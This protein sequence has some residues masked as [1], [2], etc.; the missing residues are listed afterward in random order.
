MNN[1][2]NRQEVGYVLLEECEILLVMDAFSPCVDAALAEWYHVSLR[3]DSTSNRD[4][5]QGE[6][7]HLSNE[8]CDLILRPCISSD[9][10][11]ESSSHAWTNATHIIP[12]NG[13]VS[14]MS[15]E[16]PS[17]KICDS[18]HPPITKNDESPF[19]LK[20]RSDA[21]LL[22]G[23]A[24]EINE[25]QEKGSSQ[26][27]DDPHEKNGRSSGGSHLRQLRMEKAQV[28]L[29]ENY[30]QISENASRTDMSAQMHPASDRENSS[31]TYTRT[32]ASLLVTFSLPNHPQNIYS[33]II[34]LGDDRNHAR[35]NGAKSIC[36][37]KMLSTAH[38]LIGS[39]IRCDWDRLD[40]TKKL[41]Q[42]KALSRRNKQTSLGTGRPNSSLTPF[43]FP[44]SLNMESL[45]E[46]ICG[47]STHFS[48]DLHKKRETLGDANNHKSLK[49]CSSKRVEFLDLPSDIIAESVAT[50]LRSKSLHALRATNR[51]LYVLLREVVPGLKLKLFQHQIRS[52]EWMEMRERRCIT[53]GDVLRV[54]ERMTS[55][56]Y[57]LDEGAKV[58]GGDYHRAVTGG[59]TVLLIPRANSNCADAPGPR[60][61]DL[62]SGCEASFA[63]APRSITKCARGGLLCDDPGLGKTI[64]IISLILRS[65]GLTTQAKANSDQDGDDDNLFYSYWC[66]SFLTK[67]VRKCAL[68]E[69]INCLI[70][71]DCES[72]W[73]LPPIDQYLDGCPDY[74][75]VISTP[76][77]LEDIRNICNKSD[78]RDFKGFEA[79]VMLCFSNAM[80]Y[81]PPHHC[82]Y[83]AAKRL[84]NNFGTLLVEFKK[85]QL[86]VASKS[87]HRAVKDPDTRSLV[88]AFQ[89]RKRREYQATLVSSS[90]TLLVVPAPLLSHW[91]EQMILHI[92]FRYIIEHGSLSSSIYY[93]TSKRNINISHTS[94]SF[95]L[96]SIT[97]PVLFIDDGSKV[98][99]QPSILA[100]FPIVLTTC[101]RFTSEWKNGS[102]EREIRASKNMRSSSEIYW[103]DDEPQA[104]PLLKVSWLRVIVDEGHV[105]G[106]STNN[107]IQFAS[108]LTVERTWAMTGTPTQQIATQTGLR[109]LY[110][111][112]NFVKHDFFDRQLGREKCW[113]DLISSGWIAGSLASFFRLKQLVSYLM[114]RHTKADLVEIPP[115]IFSTTHI[116][117]SQPETTTYNTI[118]SSIK[119]NIITTSMKGKTSGWQDSLLNP[120]QSRHASLALTNL[121][122]ACCGGAQIVP[123]ILQ[124]HWDETLVI[125]RDIH[126]LH[127]VQVNLIN[128]FIYRAQAAELSGC[129]CCGLQLQTLFIIPCGHLVCTECIDSKSTT[130]PVCQQS[131]DVDSFQRLQPGFNFQFCLKLKNEEEERKNRFAIRRVISD[132]IRPWNVVDIAEVVNNENRTSETP[133]RPHRRGESCIYSRLHSDGRCEICRKEHFDCNFMNFEQQ[134]SVCYKN[135]EQC[136]EYASKARYVI[137]KLLQLRTNDFADDCSKNIN[138]SPMAAR[139]FA[140]NGS[141]RLSQRPLKA[142]IFSQFREIY[143]YFGDRLIRRFGGACVADY[144]YAGTRS[145]EL[146]KFI[147]E[148]E[149]FVMLLS[150]Q[151]SVGLDLSF[152]T[153]IFFLD[154]IYDKSLETQVVARAY[155]MGATG[156]VFVEQ[157][158][159]K[160]SIEEIMIQMNTMHQRKLDANSYS[161]DNIAKVH[162]LLMSAKLIRP[163]QVQTTKKRKVHECG[164]EQSNH[165]SKTANVRFKD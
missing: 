137:D 49:T 42:H 98:L 113:N 129:H 70:K 106:K 105:M 91:L 90:S 99:P 160:N 158:V 30:S 74:F 24:M 141:H 43:F 50:Y 156:P 64:T 135:A 100:R 108:W 130:C 21:S 2:L 116:K 56:D 77:C 51:K 143:E 73:F 124:K 144:S 133:A 12:F 117:L 165:A 80:A 84:K 126:S 67:H 147:H 97:H 10:D 146:H 60:R 162:R 78:C 38:Q 3:S 58:C 138:V 103:G 8:G 72:A 123:N 1:Q 104:S 87:M 17:Q 26:H 128:N 41:L 37:D 140:K 145:Q 11:S 111:L 14:E 35:T 154:S 101:N 4:V 65:Y 33:N 112:T 15:L 29:W 5:E 39:I 7:N 153:H 40:R 57:F 27:G 163:L 55:Q 121:R 16:N 46:S 82:V 152:V 66:S 88:D 69:L 89:A 52:L 110:F 93:H 151:G 47:A 150:K 118:V 79:N 102:L 62:A 86:T 6:E 132:S 48:L 59:A 75:D 36:K 109:N 92:D 115:P 139:L 76:I 155:R 107:L 13:F 32:K 122:I 125:C 142:I 71:S 149:C 81:N 23:L 20:R 19:S 164:D 148:P 131:F 31:L 22:A 25:Q 83:K 96:K 34:S 45:F 159:A 61:F 134:C 157:L 18:Y 85:N 9:A 127:D 44:D 68:L 95:E 94:A 53:E 63:C 161:Q 136:P 28:M 120:R 54:H 119:A 114:V